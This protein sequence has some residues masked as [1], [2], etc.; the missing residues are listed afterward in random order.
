MSLPFRIVKLLRF[1]T[2]E[3][4]SGIKLDLVDIFEN[5]NL[6]IPNTFLDNQEKQIKII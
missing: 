1:S 3:V 5:Q 2:L 6:K 4:I